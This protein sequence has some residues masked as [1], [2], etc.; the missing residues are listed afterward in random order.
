MPAAVGTSSDC[1]YITDS[2]SWSACTL[3]R[4]F[5]DVLRQRRSS[6][7]LPM[8]ACN[9]F[10][11]RA[12]G[13]PFHTCACAFIVWC[14]CVFVRGAGHVCWCAFVCVSPHL[15]ACL[16]PC[17]RVAAHT[18]SM[19]SA[20]ACRCACVRVH[21]WVRASVSGVRVLAC[22]V[23]VRSCLSASMLKSGDFRQIG[24]Q[25][26]TYIRASAPCNLKYS[27]SISV[28]VLFWFRFQ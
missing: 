7:C 14:A 9:V 12:H 4:N 3:E 27:T 1:T 24:S 16:W 6:H 19:E 25:L 11:A 8:L 10:R 21:V 23:R 18:S 17:S 26:S 22:R 2:A 28:H 13:E 15:R 20:W 5:G